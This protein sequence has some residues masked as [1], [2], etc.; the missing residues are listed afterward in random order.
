MNPWHDIS[1]GEKVPEIVT[2]LIE[3][4]S[5]SKTKFEIDKKS[6]LLKVDRVLY[7]SVHYPANYGFIPQTYCGDKDPLDILVLGQ[8]QVYPLSLM[9]ARPIGCMTMLDQGEM[10]DKIIA[11]HA[12]DPE[13]ANIFSIAD[14]APHTLKE[15]QNFFEIYKGLENKKIEVE[16]F[17]DRNEA[18]NVIA[19]SIRLYE[20]EKHNLRV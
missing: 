4:P 2:A 15:I 16:G 17:K 9:R 11:V 14:L 1:P 7:S 10:D 8:A 5:G 3:I 19:D 12:D 6:G 13:M 20:A 18:Y